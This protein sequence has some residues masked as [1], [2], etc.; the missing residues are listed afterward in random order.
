MSPT[1]TT[2]GKLLKKSATHSFQSA[3]KIRKTNDE[4]KLDSNYAAQ[5]RPRLV[6]RTHLSVRSGFATRWRSQH[7]PIRRSERSHVACTKSFEIRNSQQK[8]EPTNQS[9]DEEQRAKRRVKQERSGNCIQHGIERYDKRMRTE[10]PAAS[11]KEA[12]EW[13]MRRRYQ[14]EHAANKEILKLHA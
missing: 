13:L 3:T 6:A 5:G 14:T 12:R 2:S 8:R 1:H 11:S 7:L 10:Q 4:Q 9:D